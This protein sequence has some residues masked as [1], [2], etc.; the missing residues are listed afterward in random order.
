MT[1]CGRLNLGAWAVEVYTCLLVHVSER[2]TRTYA[3]THAHTHTHRGRALLSVLFEWVHTCETVLLCVGGL[4]VYPWQEV[5]VCSVG[6]HS[7]SLSVCVPPFLR[8]SVIIF[9]AASFAGFLIVL[10]AAYTSC[11]PANGFSTQK[12]QCFG[13][14]FFFHSLGG[15]LFSFC[16]LSIKYSWIF[17]L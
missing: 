9:W 2:E 14:F 15:Y 4:G 16:L 11:K 13:F 7:I 17:N 6:P 8:K 3:R 10:P 1:G 12:K 5:I